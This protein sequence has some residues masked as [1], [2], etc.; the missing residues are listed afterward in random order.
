MLLQPRFGEVDVPL[1]AAQD[2]VVDNAVVAE[3]QNDLPFNLEGLVGQRFVLFGEEAGGFAGATVRVR[4]QLADAI[5]VF[6]PEAVEGFLLG[7][8]RFGGVKSAAGKRSGGRKRRKI[9]S[10][11]SWIPG[12]P[13]IR[14]RIKPPKTSRI[15]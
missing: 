3:V 5:V 8:S 10:G 12:N 15:G 6:N 4:F 2:V 7:A 14:L 1:H 9:S 13:G 11:R